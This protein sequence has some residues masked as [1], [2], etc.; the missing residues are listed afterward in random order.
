MCSFLGADCILKQSK[1]HCWLCVELLR[2]QRWIPKV[3]KRVGTSA[4]TMSHLP[5]AVGSQLAHPHTKHC[6][7]KHR[8]QQCNHLWWMKWV[9][10]CMDESRT[11]GD[12]QVFVK[13]K[14]QLTPCI[15]ILALNSSSLFSSEHTLANRRLGKG[16]RSAWAIQ[17]RIN[18][19]YY[20]VNMEPNC[21]PWCC[22][23]H[24]W[25]YK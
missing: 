15:I 5:N 10:S 23:I 18:F 2:T 21:Q 17:F 14:A 25:Q 7:W 3:Y 1:C 22:C 16:G 9:C 24:G 11:L 19:A 20:F 8:R 6:W 12:D 13:I 4:S